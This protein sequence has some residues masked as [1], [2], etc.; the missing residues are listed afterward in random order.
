MHPSLS[1]T[2]RSPHPRLA[3]FVLRSLQTL[4]VTPMSTRRLVKMLRANSHQS[5]VTKPRL[6]YTTLVRVSL[7]TSL[8]T[9]SSPATHLSAENGTVSSA[10]L[11][12][13]T[14]APRSDP[15]KAL[16]SC[17]MALQDSQPWTG[18]SST[19]SWG[20]PPS[21]STPFCAR[22]LLPRSTRQL[23]LSKCAFSAA[24]FPLAGAP[25]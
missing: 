18:K 25:S 1:W 24:V 13:P 6:S 16:A 21:R 10:S 19:T 11:T 17:Q 15:L 5:S 22:S 20:A 23:I 4:S 9:W 14:S 3:R 8:V 7:N 2:S 12:R